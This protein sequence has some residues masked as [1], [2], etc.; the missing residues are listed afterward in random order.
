MILLLSMI[1]F[2]AQ[3]SSNQTKLSWYTGNPAMN[4]ASTSSN[5]ANLTVTSMQNPALTIVKS[6][7]PT[8]YSTVGQTITYIYN[9]TNSGDVDIKGPINIIDSLINGPISIPNTDLGPGQSITGTSNYSIT[10]ADINSGS[11]TI[12]VYAKILMIV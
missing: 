12:S 2:E 6:A 11:V 7:S 8:N 5:T 1:P 4:H 9:V 3:A 10:Q